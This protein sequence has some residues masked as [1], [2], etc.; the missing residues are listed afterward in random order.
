MQSR[1][2]AGLGIML[3]G[4]PLLEKTIADLVLSA[5]RQARD[6]GL[7]GTE[8]SQQPREDEKEIRPQNLEAARAEQAPGRGR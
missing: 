1:Y 8:P 3:G 5:Q 2:L 4:Q 7:D 6:G